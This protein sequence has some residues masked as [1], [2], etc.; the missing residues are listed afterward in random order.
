MKR[1][2]FILLGALLS[3]TIVACN[4]GGGSSDN[5]NSNDT[6]NTNTGLSQLPSAGIYTGSSTIKISGNNEDG[7]NDNNEGGDNDEGGGITENETGEVNET[8]DARFDV[9][10]NAGNQ[11]IEG[12][13]EINNNTC[14]NG[15]TT[16]S[17]AISTNGI[18]SFKLTGC[19]DNNNT[20]S[21]TYTD[22]LGNTGTVQI[23]HTN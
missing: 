4:S 1:T 7:T 14:F 2:A 17:K 15:T 5:N 16:N 23:T 21:A 20:I 8:G 19:S 12:K 3:L 11:H 22:G 13:F 9:T 6:P 18:T 10:T